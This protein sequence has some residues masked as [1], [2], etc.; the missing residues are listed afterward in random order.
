MLAAWI[1]GSDKFKS[2]YSGINDKL[3][4]QSL[5]LDLLSDQY[6]SERQS[7][8]IPFINRWQ[9][10]KPDLTLPYTPEYF[11][12]S[13]LTEQS[14][15]D[16]LLISSSPTAYSKFTGPSRESEQLNWNSPAIVSKP[17]SSRARSNLCTK[18]IA[19][20][21]QPLC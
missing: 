10:P 20:S 1:Y 6:V 9:S 7:A 12:E 19:N 5:N 4:P 13:I 18:W 15:S 11:T 16:S 2:S 3:Y 8:Y 14:F 21:S 17:I